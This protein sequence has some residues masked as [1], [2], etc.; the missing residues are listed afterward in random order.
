MKK[1]LSMLL[2][3]TLTVM[4]AGCATEQGDSVEDKLV[5]MVTDIGGVDDAS[6]NQSAWEGLK[7]FK[8]EIDGWTVNYIESKSDEDYKPNLHAAVDSGAELIWAIGYMMADYLDRVALD[9][10]D[11]KFAIIDWGT[12]GDLRENVAYVL[13]RENEGSFLVGMIAGLTTESNIIGFVG[14]MEGD[15][16]RRFEVGFQA[17]INYVNPDAENLVQYAQSWTDRAKGK[18]IATTM[19][20]QGADVIYH[21]AGGVGIGVAEACSNNRVWFI[22]VD[23]DQSE[24]APDYTLTSM[25]KRVDSATY[26]ISKSLVDGDF[27]GGTLAHLGL[28]EDGV[29]YVQSEFISEQIITR[30]EE[31]KQKIIDGRLEVPDT[32]EDLDSFDRTAQ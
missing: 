12:E 21:A 28:A 27:P 19:I 10:P 3:L 31:A 17:G 29:G 1:W 16:I 13:F 7:R 8:D 9:Y 24:L 11:Q 2:A 26:S 5:Y 32:L 30:V 20:G 23:K 22:G 25:L 18:Q 15:L 6:F 14:G 4:A